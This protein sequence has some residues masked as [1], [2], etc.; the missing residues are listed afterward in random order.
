M[1]MDL[2]VCQN[3]HEWSRESEAAAAGENVIRD[4]NGNILNDGDAVTELKILK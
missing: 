2:F 4:V 1:K 3:V